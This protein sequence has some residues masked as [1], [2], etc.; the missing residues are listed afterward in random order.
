MTAFIKALLF[1]VVAEM[2]NK[3]QLFAMAMASNYKSK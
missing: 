2:G 1:V 3:T